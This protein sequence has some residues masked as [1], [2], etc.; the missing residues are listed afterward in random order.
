MQVRRRGVGQRGHLVHDRPQP[1]RV[2]RGPVPGLGGQRAELGRPVAEPGHQVGDDRPLPLL[3]Q[4][5]PRPAHDVPGGHRLEQGA[6]GPLPARHHEVGGVPG[7]RPVAVRRPGRDLGRVAEPADEPAG[8]VLERGGRRE[9]AVEVRRPQRRG[10]QVVPDG[11]QVGGALL[12]VDLRRQLGQL[13]ALGRVADCR[14]PDV[15]GQHAVLEVMDGVG[16]VVG[17]VHDLRLQAPPPLGGASAHPVERRAVV[18]VHAVF[19]PVRPA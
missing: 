17:P 1:A 10:E 18:V 3:G 7:Q 9:T 13:V 19:A 14:Q 2:V 4:P 15:A 5:H 12:A 8:G 16:D 6:L 11:P